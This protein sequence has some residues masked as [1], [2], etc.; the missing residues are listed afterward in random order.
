MCTANFNAQGLCIFPE[1]RIFVFLLSLADFLYSTN[2]MA[3]A[4]G[5]RSGLYAVGTRF[6]GTFAKLRKA[7]VRYVVSVLPS[8]RL[9]NARYNS[10]QRPRNGFS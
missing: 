5:A 3:F 9:T 6:L 2:Q 7:T 8:V 10:A 4:G 1:G